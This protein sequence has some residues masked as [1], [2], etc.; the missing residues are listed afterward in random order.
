MVTVTRGHGRV[1]RGVVSTAELRADVE[2]VV[3]E[4]GMSFDL[5]MELG[6][7]DELRSPRLRDLWLLAGAVLVGA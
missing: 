5:F 4:E 6:Q 3:A 7:A 1:Q 2:R